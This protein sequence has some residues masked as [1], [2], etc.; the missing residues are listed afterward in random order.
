[1]RVHF[2]KALSDPSVYDG[3]RRDLSGVVAKDV[4]M[5]RSTARKGEKTAESR[6]AHAK[7]GSR[8]RKHRKA[9]PAHLAMQTGSSE[10]LKRKAGEEALRRLRRTPS[11]NLRGAASSGAR[12]ARR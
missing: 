12:A 9:A 7:H 2:G 8:K 11:S 3:N 10:E 5:A 1:M 4:K 6:R